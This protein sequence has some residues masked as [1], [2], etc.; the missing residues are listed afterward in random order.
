MALFAGK[1]GQNPKLLFPQ[2]RDFAG[3]IV[4][5]KNFKESKLLAKF[6]LA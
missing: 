2:S 3:L 1:K 6:V 4:G 5:T